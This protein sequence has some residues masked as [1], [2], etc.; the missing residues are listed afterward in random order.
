MVNSMTGFAALKGA[1]HGASWAWEVRSV[2]ARGLDLRLRLAEGLDDLEITVRKA[3]SEKLTRGNVSLGL[4][5]QSNAANA[6]AGLVSDQLDKVLAALKIVEQRAETIDLHLTASSAADVLALRG[7]LDQSDQAETDQT[8]L[9]A[10]LKA[11]IPTLIAAFSSARADE[12]RALGQ[13]LNEQL[14]RIKTLVAEAAL[15]AVERQAQVAENLQV[16]LKRVLDNSEGADSARVAQELAMLAVKADV[17][18][19]IDRLGAQ[20]RRPWTFWQQKR[21]LGENSIS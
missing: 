1:G 6:A 19:E 9:I 2:N 3:F 20:F 13:I 15:A 12:G 5:L 18:E 7:V 21:R 11:Q 10:D 17:A 4:R 8:A 16:N 14:A